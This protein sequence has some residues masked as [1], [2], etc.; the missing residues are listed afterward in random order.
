MIGRAV[1]TAVR[2]APSTLSMVVVLG[3]AAM[4]GRPLGWA[5]L[6]ITAM[7]GLAGLSVPLPREETSG[8]TAWTVA[9]L[10]GVSA[11]VAAGALA[12]PGAGQPTAGPAALAASVVAAV[13]EEAF[14][15]RAVYGWLERWSPAVAVGVTA[16]IFAAIHIPAYGTAAL[17]VNLG[18]GVLFG[19]QRWATGGWA[20]P[21]ATHVAANLLALA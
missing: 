20:A 1:R 3:V 19:W 2:P 7:V 21:A 15:R 18:A 8:R 12:G 13:A 9:V 5:G 4:A 17:P 11:L 16:L 14:F 6:A 10:V